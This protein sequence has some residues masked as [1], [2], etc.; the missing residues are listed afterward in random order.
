MK[1]LKS[2]FF[3]SLAAFLP[4]ACGPLKETPSTATGEQIASARL[5]IPHS[6]QPVSAG[7]ESL[8]PFENGLQLKLNDAAQVILYP[9][10]WSGPADLSARVSLIYDLQ[11]LYLAAEVQDDEIEYAGHPGDWSGDAVNL[12]LKTETE[13]GVREFLF[14]FSCEGTRYVYFE[15]QSYNGEEYRWGASW[16]SRRPA[17]YLVMAAIPFRDLGL[18][19]PEQSRIWLNVSVE[20]D[21]QSAYLIFR[22]QTDG[23]LNDPEWIPAAF[24]GK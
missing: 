4:L 14:K 22:G 20:D 1:I 7:A 13:E 23:F 8:E 9:D 18:L 16:A 11:H 10:K 3:L 2:L 15:R 24:G 5:V 17:G 21:H 6:P 12:L 19:Y